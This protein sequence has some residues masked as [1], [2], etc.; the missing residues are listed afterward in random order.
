MTQASEHTSGVQVCRRCIMDTASDASVT[1]DEHGVC[2]H[3]RNHDRLISSRVLKGREGK[4]ALEQL[5]GK[6][7]KAGLNRE[8]DCIIGVSGGVDSTYVAY[9]VKQMGLRPLAVPSLRRPQA[10]MPVTMRLSIRPDCTTSIHRLPRWRNTF[11]I[12]GASRRMT[13]RRRCIRWAPEIGR[14]R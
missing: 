9:L 4:A 13:L 1:F 3:C 11:T 14:D 8:Y 5:T 6:I 2:S 7:K 12:Y 10:P